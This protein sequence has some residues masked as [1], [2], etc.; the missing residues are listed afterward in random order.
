MTK[1]GRCVWLLAGLFGCAA[2]QLVSQGNQLLDEGR[3]A[4]ALA[5][6]EE[7]LKV[8]PDNGAILE[9][10]KTTRRAAVRAKLDQAAHALSDAQYAE[11]LKLAMQARRMPMD[12][13]DV[14]LV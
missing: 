14:D 3:H 6:C 8:E 5:K 1:L 2:Q 13:D 10:M 7:A 9:R 12:L 11:A 4:E